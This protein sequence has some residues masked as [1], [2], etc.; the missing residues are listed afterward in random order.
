M[1]ALDEAQH[2]YIAARAALSTAVDARFNQ[3]I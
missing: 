3:K 1:A 2:L